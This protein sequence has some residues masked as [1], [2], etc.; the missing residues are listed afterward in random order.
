MRFWLALN[1]I[2]GI[3]KVVYSTLVE[4]FGNP[5]GVFEATIQE[6]TAIKGLRRETASVIKGFKDW[7]W[8][9]QEMALMERHDVSI[10]TIKDKGY[11]KNLLTTYDP[12]PYLYIKGRIE[13]VDNVA[14][15]VVGSRIPTPYGISVAERMAGELASNGVTVVS[16]MARGIDSAAHRGALRAN[17]RTIAVL[18]CGVDVIYPKENKRLYE[19]ICSSGAVISEFP[20]GT[21][22]YRANFPLRNRV[23]SGLSLGVVVV[24]AGARSGSLITARLALEAG[25]EVFAIP[26]SITSYRSKGT[27][28][29]LKEGAKLV[30][31][32]GDIL[33]EFSL[34]KRLAEDPSPRV[35]SQ[36]ERILDLL[37]DEPLFIDTIIQRTG[38]PAQQ[39]MSLLLT[40]ELKGF[41]SQ[42]PGM[43][44]M[45]RI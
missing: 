21:P 28:R 9:E 19:E 40:L 16:G 8:V 27:N 26:G 42:Q 20:M 32:V 39:V 7:G 12:P 31:D 36:E 23:I 13:E 6:L 44:F 38:L 37:C 34:S 33:E 15:A 11:P 35:S 22:P 2:P 17:G 3:G 41:I 4:R 29:L 1:Y 5:A 14:V 30:E 25:R 43:F 24:E 18:G 10:L 45:K